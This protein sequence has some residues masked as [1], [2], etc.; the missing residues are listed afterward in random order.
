MLYKIK[1]LKDSTGTVAYGAVFLGL[2]RDIISAVYLVCLTWLVFFLFW[3]VND[4]WFN[5]GLFGATFYGSIIL[6]L[7]SPSL[8]YVYD[9]KSKRVY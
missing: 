1:S 6:A 9:F 5:L 7:L 8:I 3:T 2:V 4:P